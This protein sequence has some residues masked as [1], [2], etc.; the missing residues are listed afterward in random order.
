MAIELHIQTVTGRLEDK[1]EPSIAY[2]L[3]FEKE[4]SLRE[5]SYFY[6]YLKQIVRHIEDLIDEDLSENN[7]ND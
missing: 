7:N 6:I 4:Y 3:D 1:E 2:R 5:L